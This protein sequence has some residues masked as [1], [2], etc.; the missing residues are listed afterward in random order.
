MPI[1]SSLM[2]YIR[3]FTLLTPIIIPTMA[4]FSSL[5][6]ANFK[7]FVYVLGLTIAMT[8]SSFIA[9]LIGKKVPGETKG[10]R[11]IPRI[12]AACN[13][14]GNSTGGWGTL[15]SA[16]GPHALVMAFTATYLMFPMFLNGTINLGLIGAII[17]IS[18]ISAAIRISSP[19]TCITLGDAIAGWGTGFIFGAI[20]YFTVI[21]LAG[22][23][24]NL[25]YFEDVKSDRQ[26][27][28]INKKAFRCKRSTAAK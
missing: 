16:P 4:I 25:T 15:Y 9:P 22:T 12:D 6:D 18:V 20:W 26:Q 23:K 8:F 21:S 3:F 19:M 11:Y 1:A 13:L 24:S 14:I 5:F 10:G 28:T 2:S 7:G 27:C 17:L